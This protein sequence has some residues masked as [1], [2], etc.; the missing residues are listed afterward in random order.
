MLWYGIRLVNL[1][2]YFTM[3]CSLLRSRNSRR[4]A[5]SSWSVQKLRA[6]DGQ[7]CPQFLVLEYDRAAV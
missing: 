2:H 6:E 4:R 1:L 7:G 3:R 5:S